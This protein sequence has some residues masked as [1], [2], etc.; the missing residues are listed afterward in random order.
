MPV[1]LFDPQAGGRTEEAQQQQQRLFREMHGLAD[2]EVTH[3]VPFGPEAFR[4]AHA[5]PD[6]ELFPTGRAEEIFARQTA[7]ER[8]RSLP[9][10]DID[11]SRALEDGLADF[12]QRFTQQFPGARADEWDSH[13]REN[14]R[15]A[16][17]ARQLQWTMQEARAGDWG[18]GPVWDTAHEIIRSV[19]FANSV[20][21][22]RDSVQLRSALQ[23]IEHGEPT[24]EDYGIVASVLVQAEQDEQLGF[25]KKMF[26]V[27]RDMAPWVGELLVL[28]PW[29]GATTGL[30]AGSQTL[31]RGLAARL[32]GAAGRLAPRV[33]GEIAGLGAASIAMPLE[34]L[35]L[36]AETI[37]LNEPRLGVDDQGVIVQE[38]GQRFL[39]GMPAA[40][41]NRWIES[42]TEMA[43]PGISQVAGLAGRGLGRLASETS[44]LALPQQARAWLGT[45]AAS[46]AIQGPRQALRGMR[47]LL[48]R[49][50]FQR[51]GL[52]N[53]LEEYGEERLADLLHGTIGEHGFGT[54]GDIATLNPRALDQS[55]VELLA[56]AIIG[57]SLGAVRRGTSSRANLILDDTIER[58]RRT[59]APPALID[60]EVHAIAQRLT[61]AP[62]ADAMRAAAEPS[63][64]FH[65]WVQASAQEFERRA[66]REH[67][68]NYE[69]AEHERAHEEY[70]RAFGEQRRE[71]LR[72]IV[73]QEL[74]NLSPLSPQPSPPSL[75]AQGPEVAPENPPVGDVVSPQQT[76]NPAPVA[77]PITA[78]TFTAAQT[79]LAR[80]VHGV[81]TQAGVA[82]ETAEA[83]R[84]LNARRKAKGLAKVSFDDF[85]TLVAG[86]E[87]KGLIERSELTQE[88]LDQ[89][90][91][92]GENI[93]DE[94]LPGTYLEALARDRGPS[95]Q[96]RARIEAAEAVARAA[97]EARNEKRIQRQEA[98]RL[99]QTKLRTIV[100]GMGGISVGRLGA[101]WNVSEDFFQAG[102]GY[103]LDPEGQGLDDLADQLQAAGHL[104]VPADRN[105]DD[106]LMERLQA[107]AL[108]ALHEDQAAL[109]EEEKRYHEEQAAQ[110]RHQEQIDEQIQRAR[111]AGYSAGA[112]AGGVQRGEESARVEAE[113]AEAGAADRPPQGEDRPATDDGGSLADEEE[114]GDAWEPPGSS[115][116]AVDDFEHFYA[117][118]ALARRAVSLPL[119]PVPAGTPPV[120]E[121]DLIS[122]HEIVQTIGRLFD[123]PIHPDHLR[124]GTLGL[125][126]TAS[127]AIRADINFYGNIIVAAHE[128]GHHV[129][130]REG[131]V[132]N[133]PFEIREFLRQFDYQENRENLEVARKEGFAE[134]VR[135]WWTE[136][137]AKPI[138]EPLVTWFEGWLAA[139]PNLL[140]KFVR[141]KELIHRYRAMAPEQRVRTA[142][143]SGGRQAEQPLLSTK[144]QMRGFASGVWDGWLYNFVG[145]GLPV[146]R[147][148]DLIETRQGVRFLPGQGPKGTY[149]ALSKQGPSYALWSI[150]QGPIRPSDFR[151]ITDEHGRV[152]GLVEILQPIEPGLD[153]ERASAYAYA[154]HA[155]EAWDHMALNPETRQLEAAPINPGITREDAEAT[156]TALH[157]P[158]YEAFADGLTRFA[159]A[160]LDVL[161]DAGETT[162]AD[163]AKFKDEWKFYLP[164]WRVRPP[165]S[166]DRPIAGTRYV[167]VGKFVKRRTGADL[168]I[169]N[170]AEALASRTFYIYSKAVRQMVVSEVVK[171]APSRHR[172]K[173]EAVEGLGQLIVEESPEMASAVISFAQMG[174]HVLDRLAKEGVFID[175]EQLKAAQDSVQVGMARVFWAEQWHKGDQPIVRVIENGEYRRYRFDPELYKFLAGMD[176]T[177]WK[178]IDQVWPWMMK[179][180]KIFT[181]AGN[182]SFAFRNFFRDWQTF[183]FQREHADL[184]DVAAVPAIVVQRMVGGL[185]SFLA[186]TVRHALTGKNLA[187]HE[188]QMEQLFE[189]VGGQYLHFNG[190]ELREMKSTLHQLAF[191][192]RTSPL[193][194][195]ARHP[196][197]TLVNAVGIGETVPRFL[198]FKAVLDN[199]GYNEK[200][201]REMDA[202][203]ERP[204]AAILRKAKIAA[205]EVTVNFAEQG[206]TAK[207]WNQML[208]YFSAH[209]RGNARFARWVRDASWG[210][211][212]L[213]LL[214]RMA[215]FLAGTT[216]LYLL[217]K[218]EDWWK[219]LDDYLKYSALLAPWQNQAEYR[220]PLNEGQGRYLVANWIG[221]LE[222]L[223]KKTPEP[224]YDSF[225][226]ALNNLFTFRGPVVA[227]PLLEVMTGLDFNR[228]FR[229]LE[230][231]SVEQLP[232]RE[233]AYPT[234]TAAASAIA[235]HSPVPISPI[236]AEHLLDSISGRL[237]SAAFNLDVPR[238]LGYGGL[239]VRGEHSRSLRTYYEQLGQVREAAALAELHGGRPPAELSERL[240]VLNATARLMTL[241]REP[242]RFEGDRATRFEVQQYLIGLARAVQGEPVLPR[243]PNPLL[244]ASW[245][246][247]PDA[248]RD[249]VHN[250]LAVQVEHAAAPEPT[251]RGVRPEIFEERHANWER[252]RRHAQLILNMAELS[253]LEARNLLQERMR[254]QA[255]ERGRPL[256]MTPANARRLN[257]AGS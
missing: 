60:E 175:A 67:L 178:G 163:A 135:V 6:G 63:S 82:T 57:G 84:Q 61:A 5:I 66:T 101:D 118:G 137:T 180:F 133:A 190:M 11:E 184:T 194:Q 43:G 20:Q 168:Q 251:R 115:A 238:L 237:F 97:K 13:F 18:R 30:R 41:R 68:R 99:R 172:Q 225:V 29:G 12:R 2:Q 127:E 242:I 70:W 109:A 16:L 140:K 76:L 71:Q 171:Y 229:P 141:I 64:P 214:T 213:R 104:R 158:R 255:A 44:R 256:R 232:L 182:P 257:R 241:L 240:Y 131:A 220:M 149:D 83:W 210:D 54:L 129:D 223:R 212:S 201:L 221:L 169:V 246:S 114:H 121:A 38:A 113:A 226:Q 245:P 136:D 144:E 252:Q 1:E 249:T 161:V 177:H 85:K 74:P 87:A 39:G 49:P 157:N 14:Y 21:S 117:P 19:H 183:F 10:G 22:I 81:L 51:A 92:A 119:P 217:V 42:V 31:A 202:R 48:A 151:Q 46:A 53:I 27:L 176:F 94:I 138:P 193:W 100:K 199:A 4:R 155:V 108:S 253:P 185:W 75:P 86:M 93:A 186:G 112:I 80:M 35:G 36:T 37:R 160:Q 166:L 231:Q 188:S 200:R 103:L 145:E 159:N 164:L 243:Y 65:A 150:Q 15:R 143:Q 17:R 110:R 230:N 69:P 72:Q 45:L 247:M 55:A 106:Y 224:L 59:G 147:L 98:K 24:R 219:E 123:V 50:L 111:R 207:N 28:G 222:S 203:G 73:E 7:A 95:P 3:P 196:W 206:A 236:R 179:W 122:E 209:L 47:Q 105:A 56:F 90:R 58:L 134:V 218:D 248:V 130:K 162:A 116:A 154:R 211:K 78:P 40:Y 23:R 91:A 198:E 146:Q 173:P 77:T 96:E 88:E 52:S 107:D 239:Q 191:E 235:Q 228:G 9:A 79:K 195:A 167:N 244:P 165:G 156:V 227:T 62:N 124:G 197:I 233:R 208:P 25:G 152:P 192:R 254:R 181:T 89:R 215:S 125:Y 148:Q 128:T 216:A 250:F 174:R 234:T 153:F 33:A 170:P 32:P 189:M 142:M 204:P 205:A 187:P 34:P 132:E 126:L 26:D 8:S 139:R 120:A 102:I